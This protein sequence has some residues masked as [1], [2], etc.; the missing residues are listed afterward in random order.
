MPHRRQELGIGESGC[1]WVASRTTPSEYG[2]F[3]L[4]QGP[5]DFEATRTNAEKVAGHPDATP[6]RVVDRFGL[7]THI[8]VVIDFEGTWEAEIDRMVPREGRLE[9]HRNGWRPL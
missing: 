4:R 8:G 7:C 6:F 1:A 2:P 9:V 3:T 5:D